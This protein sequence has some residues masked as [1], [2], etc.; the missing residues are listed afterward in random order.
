MTD[1]ELIEHLTQAHGC[2]DLTMFSVPLE[3][4]HLRLH[5]PHPPQL[6]VPYFTHPIETPLSKAIEEALIHVLGPQAPEEL[7]EITVGLDPVEEGVTVGI[8]FV[9]GTDGTWTVSFTDP[10]LQGADEVRLAD[11]LGR[12]FAKLKEAR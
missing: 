9:R 8:P 4:V 10:L 7:V 11:V 12:A 3:Q 5:F 2:R 1:D 6:H